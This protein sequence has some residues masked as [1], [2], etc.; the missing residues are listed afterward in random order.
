MIVF[1]LDKSPSV[2]M[3]QGNSSKVQ[4]GHLGTRAFFVETLQ[5]SLAARSPFRALANSQFVG[6]ENLRNQPR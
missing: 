4:V 3:E 6:L 5:L 1:L 2:S